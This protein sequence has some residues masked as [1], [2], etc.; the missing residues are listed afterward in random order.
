MALVSAVTERA[1]IERREK[2]WAELEAIVRIVDTRGLRQLSA[3][4]LKNLSPLYRDVCADLAR[5]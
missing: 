2:E 4:D 1:F 3:T 5:A